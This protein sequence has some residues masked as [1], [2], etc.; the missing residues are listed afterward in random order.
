[1]TT[2]SNGWLQ[3]YLCMCV[4]AAK[5]NIHL[6]RL[7]ISLLLHSGI[8]QEDFPSIRDRLSKAMLDSVCS[9][10]QRHKNLNMYNKNGVTPVSNR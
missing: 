3:I 5:K 8:Y 2:F 1:M 9:K 10:V 4:L 6:L 7:H